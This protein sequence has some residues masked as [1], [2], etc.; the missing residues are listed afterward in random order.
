MKPGKKSILLGIVTLII[1]SFFLFDLGR[2]LD[3]SYI[4]TQQETLSAFVT[5]NLW[6]SIGFYFSIYVVATGLSLP[7]AAALTLL[8]GALFGTLLGSVVV[9]FAS[10]VGATVAFLAA[11]YLA[12][13]FVSRRFS[14][15][16]AP[17]NR[18]IER[19][20]ISYLF[21]LRLIPLFPFFAINLVMGVTRMPVKTY[22]WV[23][24]LGMLPATIIYVNAGTQL[25]ALEDIQGI[26]SPSILASLALLGLFPWI[27][28]IAI[29]VVQ[30]HRIYRKFT[31]P[32]HFDRNLLVI[33]A[34]ANRKMTGRMLRQFIEKTGI[35]F[36][37]TQMGK[38]VID[39]RHPLFLGCA[40]LSAG[41]FVHRAVEDADCIINVG[42][43]VIEKPPF[44]MEKG[45]KQVIHIN[46]NAR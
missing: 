39:E 32:T 6:L 29:K 38:G 36:L 18:G 8:G 1:L 35:P 15:L 20:G 10:S 44:F 7:G 28:R 19:D 21:S 13:S 41:D 25:A 2:F 45:G 40:A 46:F 12:R 23:S 3:F 34:G 22:Y 4:K 17:I 24:Q 42:H 26:L 31:K 11:R 33:G 9:S 5:D 43:D 14:V 27:A 16:L 37:T 30:K